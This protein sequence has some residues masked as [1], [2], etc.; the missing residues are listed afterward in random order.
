MQKNEPKIV[1]EGYSTEEIYTWMKQKITASRMLD[2]ALVE[3]EMLKRALDDVDLRIDELTS[4]S[5]LELLSK[6]QGPTRL[7]EPHQNNL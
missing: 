7:H 5:A 4:S 1:A 6:T 3:R 2:A